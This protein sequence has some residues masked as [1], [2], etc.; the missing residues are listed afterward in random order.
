MGFFNH[1]FFVSFVLYAFIGCSFVSVV[2]FRGFLALVGEAPARV[3]E[4]SG[5]RPLAA[6]EIPK[7]GLNVARSNSGVVTDFSTSPVLSAVFIVG[8]IMTSAF[9]FA[10]GIFVAFHL[11]LVTRGKTT[12][13]IYDTMDQA[14][15]ARIAR[16]DLGVQQNFKLVFGNSVWLWPLP[17][18]QRI[19]GDGLSY[20]RCPLDSSS[21]A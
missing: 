2:G 11:Y 15:A 14:R 7:V 10:L 18:R 21:L 19:D 9:S 4:H 8:Y 13:E 12:I 20:E 5:G 17:T 6:V 1:K 16:Y 3:L